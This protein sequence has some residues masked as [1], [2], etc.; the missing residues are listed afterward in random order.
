MDGDGGTIGSILG[1]GSGGVKIDIADDLEIEAD[2]GDIQLDANVLVINDLNVGGGII[3]GSTSINP[4]QGTLCGM[5]RSSDPT[6]PSENQ[7]VIWMSDGT[8]KG[9]AGDIMIASKAGG[10]TNYGT[11]FDHSGGTGW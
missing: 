8:G 11:L 4:S 5:E 7:F 9:D 10:T 3:A 1:D 2:G 6:E